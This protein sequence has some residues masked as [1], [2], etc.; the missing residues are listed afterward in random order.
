MKVSVYHFT[1][2]RRSFAIVQFEGE[3]IG[4]FLRVLSN[5]GVEEL[6][7][8]LREKLGLDIV[9]LSL[10]RG[11]HVYRGTELEMIYLRI[12]T[13]ESRYRI[14]V[15]EESMEVVGDEDALNTLGFVNN[16]VQLFVPNIVIR[17]RS[18]IGFG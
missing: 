14:E 16:L 17:R 15:Y 18:L 4:K 7:K 8:I 13:E 5:I 3:E 2:L 1:D 9:A 10:A 6:D 12:E 11:K